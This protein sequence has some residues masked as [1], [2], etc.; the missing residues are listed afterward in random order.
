MVERQLPKLHTRVRFPSPAPFSAKSRRESNPSSRDC[1]ARSARSIGRSQ[2]AGPHESADKSIP[3]TRSLD[4]QQFTVILHQGCTNKFSCCAEIF[5]RCRSIGGS[6]RPASF[7]STWETGTNQ[8]DFLSRHPSAQLGEKWAEA[9][10]SIPALT[11][12][13]ERNWPRVKWAAEGGIGLAELFSGDS[14][15]RIRDKE[16]PVS[17]PFGTRNLVRR[18]PFTITSSTRGIRRSR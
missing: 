5:L 16:M 6:R 11:R 13:S 8:L 9:R 14:Q 17:T 7:D 3:F 12:K 4:Y 15:N 2:L 18:I 10:K 1:H